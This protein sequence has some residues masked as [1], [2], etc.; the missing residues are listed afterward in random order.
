MSWMLALDM[1]KSISL[2]VLVPVVAAVTAV[3]TAHWLGEQ[4]RLYEVKSGVLRELVGHRPI[5]RKNFAEYD[6]VFIITLSS[7]PVIFSANDEVKTS[8]RLFTRVLKEDREHP[9]TI[10]AEVKN[11]RFSD[12]VLAICRSL[13]IKTKEDDINLLSS[14]NP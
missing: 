9:G 3:Y 13:S 5:Y 7:I 2:P 11:K 8:W 12:L 1:L 6:Q 14:F 4:Q 10:E